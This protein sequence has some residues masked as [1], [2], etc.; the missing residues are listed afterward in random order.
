VWIEE[1]LLRLPN[2]FKLLLN[3]IRKHNPAFQNKGTLHLYY[4]KKQLVKVVREIIV[5]Y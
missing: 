2:A 5:I 4:K 1:I 3:N